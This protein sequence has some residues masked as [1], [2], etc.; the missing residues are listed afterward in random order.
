MNKLNELATLLSINNSLGE[1]ISKIINRPATIGHTGEFIASHIF[2]IKLE[3][4]AVQK[5]I[6]G[7]FASG[8]LAGR[9]VNIKWYGKWESYLDISTTEQP[10]FYLVMTGPKSTALSSKGAVRPWVIDHVFLFESTQLIQEQKSR[11]VQI[12]IAS[13]V[14]K[15]QWLAAE[16]YPKQTNKTL[17]I[18]SEQRE[19]LQAFKSS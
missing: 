17:Q 12:G 16:I 1:K 15:R 13:S 7:H 14:R 2:N 10:D 3:E 19:I 18:N 4:S 9:S 8:D 5:A 11:G 6:D